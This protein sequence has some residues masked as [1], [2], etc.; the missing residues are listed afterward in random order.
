MFIA[1]V[2]FLFR[3]RGVFRM[4]SNFCD[5]AFCENRQRL[6]CAKS[7]SALIKFTQQANI[8]SKL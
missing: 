8:C 2:K 4:E 5:E 1:E 3:N 7:V 6:K